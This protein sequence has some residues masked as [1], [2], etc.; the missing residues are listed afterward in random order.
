MTTEERLEKLEREL[1][2]ANRCNRWLL[3]GVVLAAGL[4]A[5]AWTWTQSTAVAQAQ[6]AETAPK[7]IRANKLV[8][9]DEKGK[10]RVILSVNK[11]GASLALDDENGKTRASLNVYKDR[12]SLT[13]SDADGKALWSAP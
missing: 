7:V 11:D 8:I 13:L 10:I 5:L 1:T 9:E 12:P 6:G 3:A 4:L 2:R